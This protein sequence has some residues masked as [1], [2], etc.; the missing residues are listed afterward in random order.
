MAHSLVGRRRELDALAGELLDGDRFYVAHVHGVPGIGKSSLLSAFADRA[1][2]SGADVVLLDGR[3]V[4]PTQ[5]GF[6]QALARAL[7]ADDHAHAL[8]ELLGQSG[9]RLVILVDQYEVLRLL[10]TWLRQEFVPKLPESVRIVLAGR[11]APVAGW[12]ASRDVGDAVMFMVL[13]PLGREEAI[14]L[15]RQQGVSESSAAEVAVIAHGHPLALKLAAASV[16]ERPHLAPRDVAGQRVLEEL[17]RLYLADV[18]DPTTLTVLEAAS[19]IR[20]TTSSLIAGLVDD[21][22]PHEA[23]ERLRTLPFVEV[24]PDGLII[25]EAIQAQVSGYLRASDPVRHRQLRRAAWHVLRG[26]VRSAGPEQ[27]WRYTADMLYLIENPVVREA[28]FPSGAQPLAVEPAKASDLPSIELISRRHDGEAGWRL[29]EAWWRTQPGAFSVV[30]D[31]DGS[32]RGFHCLLEQSLLMP[33]RVDD[34]VVN[35]WWQQVQGNPPPHGQTILGYR[36]WLDIEY[37][38]APCSTQAASWLDVK[39]TYMVLRPHLRRMFTVVEDPEPYLQVVLKLGFRPFDEGGASVGERHYTSVALDFGPDS[40]DGWLAAL[41]ADELGLAP[42]VELDAG[43]REV[44]IHGSNVQLTELELGV[45]RCLQQREGRAVTRATM[46]EEVWG[47]RDDVGSNVVDA[48]V[49]RLRDKLGHDQIQTVRGS[50][51]RL[52]VH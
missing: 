41:V 37:G 44:R 28:F 21:V 45:L 17:T 32:V 1:R 15:L 3:S 27:L 4:E 38:E 50:G 24:G 6:E 47:Y 48:V 31:R 20:R 14:E 46:L 8:G 5:R 18:R 49:R 12:M 9:P 40:V 36:R 35:G 26:E 16:A 33:P 13:E 22:A 11:E 39:R 30:R 19:V 10:D 34:P 42:A 43:S 2:A 7:E 29:M 23:I 51:Y 25:H 52:T